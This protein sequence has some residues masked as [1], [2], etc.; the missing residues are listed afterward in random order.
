MAAHAI[1]TGRIS[2]LASWPF[3]HCEQACAWPRVE[4]DDSMTQT[5]RTLMWLMLAVLAALV[6]Y[7]GFRG[8]LGP[9]LLLNFANTVYC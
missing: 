6:S 7:S 3:R 1:M 9:E 8:Y 2:A 5:V 4:R